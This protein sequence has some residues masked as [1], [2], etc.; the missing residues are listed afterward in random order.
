MYIYMQHTY[1]NNY[2]HAYIHPYTYAYTY[3]CVFTY[4]YRKLNVHCRIFS[5]G[6]RTPIG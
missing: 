6:N 1:I 4:A 2:V 5:I 3:V